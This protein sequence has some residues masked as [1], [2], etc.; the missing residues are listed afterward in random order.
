MPFVYPP[1]LWTQYWYS[2]KRMTHLKKSCCWVL[3]TLLFSSAWGWQHNLLMTCGCCKLILLVYVPDTLKFATVCSCT[4][5]SLELKTV[6]F[7]Q[8]SFPHPSELK[9]KQLNKHPRLLFE[10]FVIYSRVLVTVSCIFKFS[11]WWSL[12]MI[13][14]QVLTK[15]WG[16]LNVHLSVHW[17]KFLLHKL[18]FWNLKI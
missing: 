10:Y 3:N 13:V 11:L 16:E 14:F 15:H 17:S 4:V 9:K 1:P 12:V 18:K 6:H 8:I 2:H 5:C 7:Q